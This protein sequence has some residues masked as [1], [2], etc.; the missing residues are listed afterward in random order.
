MPIKGRIKWNVKNRVR[1]ALSIANP[2]QTHCIKSIPRYGMAES[3]L[4]ITVAP[5]KYICPHGRTYPMKAVPITRKRI[6]TPTNF[7]VKI[8]VSQKANILSETKRNR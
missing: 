2:H 4:V 8:E 3:K 6:I 1:V 7:L 5:Q